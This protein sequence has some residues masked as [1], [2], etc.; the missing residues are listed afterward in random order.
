MSANPVDRMG[1]RIEVC[2]TPEEAR[3]RLRYDDAPCHRGLQSIADRIE[4]RWGVKVT[5]HYLRRATNSKKLNYHII[6][7]VIHCSDRQLYDFI[8][9]GTRKVP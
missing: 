6:G 7:H 8:I 5:T 3:E 1:Y 2:L 4:E 9:L